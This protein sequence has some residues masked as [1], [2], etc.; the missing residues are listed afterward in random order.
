MMARI[1]IGAEEPGKST[2]KQRDYYKWLYE[3]WYGDKADDDEVDKMTFT[4][5][6]HEISKLVT[7]LE[8]HEALMNDD[9]AIGYTGKDEFAELSLGIRNFIKKEA[10]KAGQFDYPKTAHVDHGTGE[11]KFYK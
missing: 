10:I 8:L 3:G 7:K 11:I 5:I 4:E 2:E 1:R 6:S 9:L